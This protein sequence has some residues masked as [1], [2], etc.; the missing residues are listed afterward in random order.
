[1]ELRGRDSH[2]ERAT[3]LLGNVHAVR[4]TCLLYGKKYADALKSA[5]TS[6]ELTKWRV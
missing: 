4:A 6:L 1:M 5:E 3:E 2:A